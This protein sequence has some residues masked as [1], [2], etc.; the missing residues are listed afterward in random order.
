MP[1]YKAILFMDTNCRGY[2]ESWYVNRAAA[3]SVTRAGAQ[4]SIPTRAEIDA[5]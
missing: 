1:V 4:S 2:S 5:S 3:I